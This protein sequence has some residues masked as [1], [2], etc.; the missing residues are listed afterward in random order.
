MRDIRD[1]LIE[2][3]EATNAEM[4]SARTKFDADRRELEQRFHEQYSAL[5]E[6]QRAL[7]VLL[8]AEGG[9]PDR[10][11]APRDLR[12]PLQD[13]IINGMH[14]AGSMSKDEVKDMVERA[15]Y[16]D[17]DG[18]GRMV[19]TTLLNAVKSGK[20][21]AQSDG[22]FAAAGFGIA[23]P[24]GAGLL[25]SVGFDEPLSEEDRGPSN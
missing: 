10:L 4:A 14:S 5:G 13:Y 24:L 25:G 1:D 22:R 11:A 8:D 12:L 19:H 15:G 3:L 23:G 21:L 18:V 20:I 9:A 7:G 16:G 6:R 17:G 2:R